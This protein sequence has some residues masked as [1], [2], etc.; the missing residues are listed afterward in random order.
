L[1]SRRGPGPKA[2]RQLADNSFVEKEKAREVGL[3]GRFTLIFKWLQ[4]CVSIAAGEKGRL[5]K[6][7]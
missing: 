3:S 1:Y 4:S 6:E 2:F 7:K 5:A